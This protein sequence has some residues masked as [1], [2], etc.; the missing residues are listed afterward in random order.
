MSGI[1]G[2]IRKDDKPVQQAEIQQML[3]AIFFRGPDGAGIWTNGAVGLGHC[4]L[5]TT[6][7]SLQ[8][9]QPFSNTR[10]DLVISADARIDNRDELVS[11]LN[12]RSRQPLSLSDSEII[13][14]AYEKWA[15]HCAEKLLGD[16]A[17]AIWDKRKQQLYCAIDH[18]RVRPLCYFNASDSFI[19]SS[20]LSGLLPG[21]LVPDEI[22]KVRLGAL[23]FS[24]LSEIDKTSSIYKDIF[25]LS[26]GSYLMTSKRSTVIREYWNP[27]A[28][29]EFYRGGDS[30][31][32]EEFSAILKEAVRCRLRSAG[33]I[34]IAM[35]G[36][37][38]SITVAALSNQLLK[39]SNNRQITISGLSDN[40]D[41]SIES[42]YV[43]KAVTT[44]SMH[45]VYITPET[46][47]KTFAELSTLLTRLETPV[48]YQEI[49]L[50][51]LYHSAREHQSKILLDGA[52][53]DTLLGLGVHYISHLF[54]NWKIRTA[55]RESILRAE[56]MMNNPYLCPGIL[57]KS[58]R[59]AYFPN[60]IR[61]Y[62]YA[63]RSRL[64]YKRMIKESMINPSFAEQI[65]LMAN[66]NR[67]QYQAGFGIT[68]SINKMR[69]RTYNQP[70]ITRMP[71]SLDMMSS[72]CSIELRHP[73]MDKRLVEYALGLPWDQ[74]NR[75]G[76]EKYILRKVTNHQVPDDI[77]WRK[78]RDHVGWEYLK[79]FCGLIYPE[80]ESMVKDKNH[81]IFEYFDY[82]EIQGLINRYNGEQ[83][84]GKIIRIYGL[85]KWLSTKIA[86]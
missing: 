48:L 25:Y 6:P 70:F 61:P 86:A 58:M 22:N 8:E 63:V 5:R 83:D 12:L 29:R 13:L 3:S 33:N 56:N 42:G 80:I 14:A 38:D 68:G 17:F 21:K 46:V 49:F 65:D 23:F 75:D 24:E 74:K 79:A 55:V 40:E 76:W 20:Q 16:F 51:C 43:R 57:V 66:L 15:E 72:A 64:K 11:L 62:T 60:F 31:Y 2:I 59:A 37:I 34:A 54:K 52:E 78:G 41:S 30:E 27:S 84:C 28:I 69:L 50:L 10:D 35:S 45:P 26:A 47:K 71:I 85:S 18:F 44:L 73:Y 36:G 77:R 67:V 39:T 1:V 82:T 53:G 9:K 7:E 32:Q 19:F 81:R 4:I